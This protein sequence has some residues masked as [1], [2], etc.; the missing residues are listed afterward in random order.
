[1]STSRVVVACRL[2]GALRFI[3]RPKDALTRFSTLTD[4]AA[5]LGGALLGTTFDAVA[6]S[7]DEARLEDA[8]SLASE[9]GLWHRVW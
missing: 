9:A 5:V 1:V 8:V 3:D 2:P 4:R 7:W 6:F